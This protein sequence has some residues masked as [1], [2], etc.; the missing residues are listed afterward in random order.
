MW[1][2]VP[3]A[4][5][6]LMYVRPAQNESTTF[7]FLIFLSDPTII[8][9]PYVS[10][11]IQQRSIAG[12]QTYTS[13]TAYDGLSIS[14][15]SHDKYIKAGKSFQVTVTIKSS[16]SF[17]GSLKNLGVMLS[18]PTADDVTFIKGKS[19]SSNQKSG[20]EYNAAEDAVYFWPKA[21]AAAVG[22]TTKRHA[23]TATYTVTLRASQY[24]SSGDS[25]WFEAAVFQPVVVGQEMVAACLHY[26]DN[27]LT[28]SRRTLA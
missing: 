7:S 20:I 18:M 5:I 21:K 11:C 13:C 4:D 27:D 24:L 17:Q 22:K 12:A 23:A 25:L 14:F 9:P 8:L 15:K 6:A 3:V 1:I 19:S 26:A 16:R 10:V 2:T 28:V